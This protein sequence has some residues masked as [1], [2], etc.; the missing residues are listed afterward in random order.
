MAER[1]FDCRNFAPLDVVKG[2]CHRSKD[3][4]AGD[5]PACELHEPLPRCRHCGHFAA[6]EQPH[7]GTCQVRE[8]GV[9]TYPDLAAVN[10]EWFQWRER[11]A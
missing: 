10:C 11:D 6:S 8:P 2:V 7:L 1:H 4:V 9:F 5:D 3:L